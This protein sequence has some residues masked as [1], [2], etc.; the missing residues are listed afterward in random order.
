MSLISKEP[1][2]LARRFVGEYVLDVVKSELNI[3]VLNRKTLLAK[4]GLEFWEMQ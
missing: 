4:F 1:S 3:C 2:I